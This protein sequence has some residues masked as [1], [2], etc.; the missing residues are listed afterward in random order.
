MQI[1]SFEELI[2]P[3]EVVRRYTSMGL[4]TERLLTVEAATQFQQHIIADCDLNDDV[5]EQVKEGYERLRTMHTY[6]ILCYE[7]FGVVS[8]LAW[9]VM[10]Q[11]FRQRFMIF[12]NG[13]IPLVNKRDVDVP[14]LAKDFDAVYEF[15]SR[16]SPHRLRVRATGEL[17]EF[18]GGLSSLQKWARKEGLLNGQRNRGRDSLHLKLRNTAAH[19]RYGNRP[20]NMSAEIIRELGEIINRLWGHPTPGGRLYPAPLVR[21]IVVLAWSDDPFAVIMAFRWDQLSEM[22]GYEDW[23]Y[24]VV[25]GGMSDDY[26]EYDAQYERTY[27]PVDLLWGPGDKA[28]C[29]AWLNAEDPAGDTVEVLDRVFACRIYGGRVSLP[30]RPDVVVSLPDDR[31]AGEWH[32]VQ[33][34]FPNDAFG[35]ARHLGQGNACEAHCSISELV[36]G[37]WDTVVAELKDTYG[38]KAIT[39]SKVRVPSR[40]LPATVEAD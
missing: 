38:A 23:T 9:L 12:F 15:V 17:M 35:H 3:V 34:D 29:S 39:L 14:L 24:A 5:P 8:N 6:G 4:S 40:S 11:A 32:V 2:T 16:G 7:L 30:R 26:W 10:E 27:F 22:D 19:S 21:E 20:P 1:R 37:T 36:A 31:R 13:E 33:A 28:E 18:R 25:R